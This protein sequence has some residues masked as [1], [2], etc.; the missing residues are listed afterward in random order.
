[1]TQI[2]RGISGIINP[3]PGLRSTID[4]AA[5]YVARNGS[6][7]EK[8][9]LEGGRREEFSFIE[10]SNP[11]NP[12]YVAKVDEFTEKMAAGEDLEAATESASTKAEQP[13][14]EAAPVTTDIAANPFTKQFTVD[15]TG[16]K[17]SP[18]DLDVLK[19]TAMYGAIHGKSFLSNIANREKSNPL[20]EFLLGSSQRHNL[21]QAYLTCYENTNTFSKDDLEVLKEETENKLGALTVAN[22][23]AKWRDDEKQRQKDKTTNEELERM[24]YQ[25]IDWQDFVVVDTIAFPEEILQQEG[26]KAD[27]SAPEPT[28]TKTQTPMSVDEPDIGIAKGLPLPEPT[29]KKQSAIVTAISDVDF[30]AVTIKDGHVRDQSSSLKR[31]QTFIDP[32]TGQEIPLDQANE[33]MRRSTISSQH[34]T[35]KKQKVQDLATSTHAP[36][37]EVAENLTAFFKHRPDLLDPP[38]Q[39]QVKKPAA[40]VVVPSQ[41]ASDLAQRQLDELTAISTKKHQQPVTVPV[42]SAQVVI[43]DDDD[44]LPPPPPPPSKRPPPP[45]S[46]APPPPPPPPQ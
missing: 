31:R 35:L 36:D 3:P 21:F 8:K 12:Y 34:H 32:A 1:M 39:S 26:K 44:S 5:A 37:A 14:E 16:I 7:F 46:H 42:P 2:P 18:L 33:H 25:T 15:L 38:Q 43:H 28:Q 30:E 19:M 29:L 17:I 23:A 40:K 11:Y 22:D 41:G 9:L 27:A 10:E 45:G 24:R 20:F 13:S 4:K 6:G